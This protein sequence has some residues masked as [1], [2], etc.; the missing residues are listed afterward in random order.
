MGVLGEEVGYGESSCTMNMDE[1]G[2]L[3]VV[4]GPVFKVESGF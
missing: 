4:T 2:T 3:T 1:R